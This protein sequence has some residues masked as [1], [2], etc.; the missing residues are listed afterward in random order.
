MIIRSS[1][2][3]LLSHKQRCVQS[4]LF[5]VFQNSQRFNLRLHRPPRCVALPRFSDRT[6][7]LLCD[8]QKKADETLF[9]LSFVKCSNASILARVRVQRLVLINTLDAEHS[10]LPSFS[11]HIHRRPLESCPVRSKTS[12]CL[13]LPTVCSVA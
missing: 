4:W 7:L 2:V 3:F 1:V 6:T 9:A 8:T 10:L 13:A 5:S 12:Q 11:F